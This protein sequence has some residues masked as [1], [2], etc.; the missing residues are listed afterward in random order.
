MLLEL[1]FLLGGKF[2]LFIKTDTS[3]MKSI[4]ENSSFITSTIPHSVKPGDIILIY[5]SENASNHGI[6]P[7]RYI[8]NFVSTEEVNSSNGPY[9][10]R[11]NGENLRKVDPF[12][13]N[14]IK[15]TN[16]NYNNT[17]Y[18]GYVDKQDEPLV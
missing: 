6:K 13:I 8:M 11:I 5:N 4:N 12:D 18:L 14:E 1:I 9:Y 17:P 10:Y 15:V 7:I 2:M 16:R 3:T